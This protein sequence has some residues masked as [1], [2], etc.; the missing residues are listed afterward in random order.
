MLMVAPFDN[1]KCD[2]T[3]F[4]RLADGGRVLLIQRLRTMPERHDAENGSRLI[5][6]ERSL[7]IERCAGFNI[8][9]A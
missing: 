2:L 1:W 5:E 9:L 3:L 8:S 7:K 4:T 6:S